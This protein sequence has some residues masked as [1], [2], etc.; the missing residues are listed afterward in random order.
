MKIEKQNAKVLF[1]SLA[2]KLNLVYS[3]TEAEAIAKI[4]FNDVLGISNAKIKLNDIVEIDT[5]KF[6]SD[7]QKLENQYPIQYLAGKAPFLDWWFEVNEHTLIPRPETEELVALINKKLKKHPKLNVLDIGTGTGCIPVSL[8]KM[9]PNWNVFGLDISKNALEIAYKNAISNQVEIE[10]IKHDILN[11]TLLIN[12]LDCI[13]SNPPYVLES[14]KQTMQKNVLDFEPTV[15][16][17]VPD[18]EALIFYE[19]I[20]AF[21]K[22]NL[23]TGGDIFFEINSLKSAEIEQLLIKYQYSE[24]EMIRDFNNKI[25]FA[26]AIKHI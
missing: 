13:I 17:F 14:E 7:T 10:F 21:A 11:N 1:N 23:K 22:L 2:T 19:A 3:L 4:Y 26:S 20:L 5:E 18:N 9:N 12:E 25:R 24:I 16:L 6:I 15:A 8:K